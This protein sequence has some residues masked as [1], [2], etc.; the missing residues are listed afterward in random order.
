MK[1]KLKLQNKYKIN[2]TL[3]GLSGCF[4]VNVRIEEKDEQKAVQLI[5]PKFWSFYTFEFGQEWGLSLHF[6]RRGNEAKKWAEAQKTAER[7]IA[8]GFKTC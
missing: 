4:T 1:R 5:K 8:S 2:C 7:F 6:F 3:N